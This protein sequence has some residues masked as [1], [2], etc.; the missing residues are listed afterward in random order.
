MDD[1]SFFFPSLPSVPD[2]SFLTICRLPLPP[3][4]RQS[5]QAG[6]VPTRFTA[7]PTL[8]PFLFLLGILFSPELDNSL[9]KH[10]NRGKHTPFKHIFS[11]HL[12]KNPSNKKYFCW[13][14]KRLRCVKMN[15]KSVRWAGLTATG[16]LGARE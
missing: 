15:V 13:D 3:A 7:L 10:K 16:R 14:E 11:T 1:I 6:D 4:D 9:D 12:E 8:Q 2:L 5:V